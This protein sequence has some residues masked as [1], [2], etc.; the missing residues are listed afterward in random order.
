MTFYFFNVV[1]LLN[2]SWTNIFIVINKDSNKHYI[3]PLFLSQS[4]MSSE[5]Q[6][7]SVKVCVPHL[8]FVNEKMNT[9]FMNVIY[10]LYATLSKIKTLL[11]VHIFMHSY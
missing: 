5:N 1:L 8:C 10:V 3:M 2:V 6:P 4:T 7:S 11:N 9:I